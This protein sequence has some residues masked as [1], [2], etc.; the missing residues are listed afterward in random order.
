[1]NADASTL[2]PA[3]LESEV[4]KFPTDSRAVK[5]GEVFFA[6]SQPEFEQNCFNGD[7]M[8]ATAF[9]EKAF[10]NG[11]IAAVVRRERFEEH[12]E[13]LEKYAEK[14]VAGLQGWLLR[15][16]CKPVLQ[17]TWQRCGR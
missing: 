10:D 14:N 2:S 11:A 3:L 12:K 8:D 13:L 1:M 6:F 17:Q 5:A 15:K 16:K 4:T 7:F 9:V